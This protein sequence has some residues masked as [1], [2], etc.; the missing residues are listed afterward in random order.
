MQVFPDACY[1]KMDTL[2]NLESS[3]EYEFLHW[4]F[5]GVVVDGPLTGIYP[6]ST[7]FLMTIKTSLHMV[8]SDIRDASTL[9]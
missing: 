9:Y 8:I 3:F 2:E 7:S 5:L 6:T 4:H 1:I